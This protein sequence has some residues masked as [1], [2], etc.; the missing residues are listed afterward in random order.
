MRP[1]K[2]EEITE[3]AELILLGRI[4]DEVIEANAARKVFDLRG[5]AL[6]RLAGV[7][8]RK[9]FWGVAAFFLFQAL[10]GV[11]LGWRPQGNWALALWSGVVLGMLS[12][13][14]HLLDDSDFQYSTKLLA[15]FYQEISE[16]R[17]RL[18]LPNLFVGH[19]SWRY[20]ELCRQADERLNAQARTLSEMT[21]AGS[22]KSCEA[23]QISGQFWEGYKFF[24]K[25]GLR[26]PP[27][28]EYL[29]ETPESGMAETWPAAV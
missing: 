29:T 3:L 6:K 1:L 24:K 28:E 7:R 17:S 27:G 5:Q 11:W 19:H 15:E 16:L 26:L 2:G 14:Y 18:D 23:S 20:Q 9:W 12:I 10:F 21:K 13:F 22:I 25:M 4:P 8:D